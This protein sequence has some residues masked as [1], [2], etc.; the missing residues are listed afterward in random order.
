MCYY[1]KDYNNLSQGKSLFW[2]GKELIYISNLEWSLGN[3][4]DSINFTYYYNYEKLAWW[5]DTE[6]LII[7]SE[8]R[9]ESEEKRNDKFTRTC[10]N[11][12]LRVH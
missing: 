9:G 8:V 3:N 5:N 7:K 11:S 2:G 1:I 4:K 10:E 6:S 12:V